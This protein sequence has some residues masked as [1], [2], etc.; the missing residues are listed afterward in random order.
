MVCQRHR[1]E[2]RRLNITDIVTTK[3]A[4]NGFY[5]TPDTLANQL[6]DMADLSG[7]KTVL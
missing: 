4:Q 5:P 1:K 2:P 6:F 7:V 3:E